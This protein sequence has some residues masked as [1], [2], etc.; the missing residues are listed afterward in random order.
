MC[1]RPTSVSRRR[2]AGLPIRPTLR[3][4]FSLECASRSRAMRPGRLFGGLLLALATL[5]PPVL[6]QSRWK[7]GVASVVIT[8]REP[9][10]MAGYSARTHPS[11]GVRQDIHAKALVLEDETAARTVLV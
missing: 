11:E 2:W 8:P 5:A 4:P 10:W 9:I 1:L 3:G 6:A 7:A